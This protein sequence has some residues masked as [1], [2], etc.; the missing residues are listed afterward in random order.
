M[1]DLSRKEKHEQIMQEMAK[2]QIVKFYLQY[3]A[4]GYEAKKQLK[5]EWDKYFKLCAET[6][7]AKAFQ[8]CRKYLAEGKL[9][10]LQKLATKCR[11]RW[12]EK[13]FDEIKKPRLADPVGMI[14]NQYVQRYLE[15]RSIVKEIAE[16]NPIMG[17]F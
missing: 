8:L 17:A 11:R 12:Q 1:S 15:S 16:G 9:K 10:D 13:E 3:E 6:P 4:M 7:E 14:K 2:K 5:N